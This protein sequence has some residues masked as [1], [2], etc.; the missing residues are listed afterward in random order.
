MFSITVSNVCDP[1]PHDHVVVVVVDRLPRA[2]FIPD[3][4][5]KTVKLDI[6]QST[7]GV[8]IL[9]SAALLHH[10]LAAPRVQAH[11]LH[12]TI[13][14]TRVR[15][16]TRA[17][18]ASMWPLQF[19]TLRP[20]PS[21]K[22]SVTPRPG[23]GETHRARQAFTHAASTASRAETR[24]SHRH[25]GLSSRGGTI[26]GSIVRWRI[27]LWSNIGGA[28]TTAQPSTRT[29]GRTKYSG[30]PRYWLSLVGVRRWI[31]TLGQLPLVP[32]GAGSLASPGVECTTAKCE[33]RRTCP[34]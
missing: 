32:H 30:M 1:F 22:G 5:R 9:H 34:R 28:T 10:L 3:P 16:E 12:F 6:E 23:I 11:P 20:T 14:R 8:F 7:N 29:S 31:C 26:Q 24:P 13:S 33:W 25:A 19:D 21:T 4:W 27:F 18:V 17:I 15:P 2:F